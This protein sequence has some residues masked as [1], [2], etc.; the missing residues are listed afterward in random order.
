MGRENYISEV[1]KRLNRIFIASK[2]GYKVPAVERH[3][4]EGFMHAGVYMDLVTNAE[5]AKVMND[6][7]VSVFGKTI[8]QR[9]AELPG[10]RQEE[11]I[12][13]SYYDQPTF[14]RKDKEII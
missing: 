2:E 9:K 8:Q 5:L 10:N 6:I 1:E 13:Y 3:R 7:H 12:D 14:E 11:A 4:L